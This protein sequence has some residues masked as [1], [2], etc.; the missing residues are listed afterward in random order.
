MISSSTFNAVIDQTGDISITLSPNTYETL[1]TWRRRSSS[2]R[3]RTA[4]TAE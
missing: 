1:L 2:C 4:A 3:S